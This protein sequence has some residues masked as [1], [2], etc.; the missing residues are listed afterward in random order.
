[1]YPVPYQLY[2]IVYRC[3]SDHCLYNLVLLGTDA[4]IDFQQIGLHGMQMNAS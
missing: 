2:V 1:M 4:A 3:S